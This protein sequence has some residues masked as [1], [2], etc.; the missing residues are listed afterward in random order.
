MIPRRRVTRIANIPSTLP[1]TPDMGII[2]RRRVIPKAASRLFQM[3]VNTSLGGRAP[4]RNVHWLLYVGLSMLAV[5]ALWGVG[6]L[7]LRY[8]IH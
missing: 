5:L 4:L 8:L 2:P 1:A 3:P 6:D 7:I